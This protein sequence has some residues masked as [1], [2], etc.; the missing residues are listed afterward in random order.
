MRIHWHRQDLRIADNPA[1]VGRDVGGEIEGSSAEAPVVG[2]F[3]FDPDVLENAAPPRL[4]FML[5]ALDSLRSA[6]SERGGELLI[7]RG[8]P[9]TVISDIAGALDA[10]LVTWAANYS[11]L[12][13]ERDAAVRQALA[14][15]GVDRHAKHQSVHHRPGTITTNKGDPYKV[16]TYFSK[17]WHDRPKE[18]SAA[19]PTGTIW[20]L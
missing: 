15:V 4:S 6:Y 18:T 1:L 9:E 20:R 10:D 17:K 14:D 16:F 5:D 7:A 19:P 3:V 8:D 13:R 11:G 12:S 2:L